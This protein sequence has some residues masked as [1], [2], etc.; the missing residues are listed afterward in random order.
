[1]RGLAATLRPARLACGAALALALQAGCEADPAAPELRTSELAGSEVVLPAD[2][3]V[4][5]YLLATV[6]ADSLLRLMRADG[7][8][9]REA[10]LPLEDLCMDPLGPRFTVALSR[11][12]EEITAYHFERGSGI[13]ACTVRVRRYTWAD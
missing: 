13:R 5:K 1:M 12:F 9:V 8:P 4:F 2:S 11:A 7:V 10:W 3:L 6:D